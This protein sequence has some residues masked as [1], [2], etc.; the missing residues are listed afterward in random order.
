ML[1]NFCRFQFLSNFFYPIEHSENR[2]ITYFENEVGPAVFQSSVQ[3]TY[4][5]QK[6]HR[7]M[8]ESIHNQLHLVSAFGILPACMYVES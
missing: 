3:Q 8:T 1:H 2:I 5:L 6:F 7:I 4:Y